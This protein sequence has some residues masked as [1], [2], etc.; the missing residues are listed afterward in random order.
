MIGSQKN[1]H[2]VGSQARTEGEHSKLG[3][4]ERGL[5]KKN[6]TG[7]FLQCLVIIRSWGYYPRRHKVSKL[8]T[9]HFPNFK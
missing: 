5:K 2:L 3:G 9:T 8:K 6:Q 1:S 7:N 4:R